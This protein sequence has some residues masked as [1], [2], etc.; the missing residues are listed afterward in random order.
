M[1]LLD[2]C[3]D[4]DDWHNA[5]CKGIINCSESIYPISYGIA[6]KWVNMTLKYLLIC[7]YDFKEKETSLHV[8]VDSYIYKAFACKQSK[9]SYAL[10]C[11]KAPTF[12][13][14]DG[15]GKLDYYR[16]NGNN[17]TQP[18]SKLNAIDYENLQCSI[19]EAI[20]DSNNKVIN[21]MSP[22]EWEGAA[23]IEQA[24]IE[25]EKNKK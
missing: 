16:E 13:E 21:R 22:I 7:G 5:L 17:R 20:R 2:D 11:P 3:T 6:Q 18:W 10:V 4:F 9:N 23:W 1:Q 12:H 24:K 8:P 19:R 25:K 15:S 14:G